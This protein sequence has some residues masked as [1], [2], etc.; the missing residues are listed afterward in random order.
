M[1]C[2]LRRQIA[3]TFEALTNPRRIQCQ[4][5]INLTLIEAL[6]GLYAELGYPPGYFSWHCFFS[7]DNSPK[8]NVFAL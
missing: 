1:I 3:T 2:P 8:A 7:F 6:V 5:P 4:T